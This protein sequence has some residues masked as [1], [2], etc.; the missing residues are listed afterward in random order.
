MPDLCVETT[1]DATVK[2]TQ[3]DTRT[4]DEWFTVEILEEQ[5]DILIAWQEAKAELVA[6]REQ[7]EEEGSRQGG[8]R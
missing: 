2:I 3:Q 4:T 6:D 7:A 8:L 5:I 1:K